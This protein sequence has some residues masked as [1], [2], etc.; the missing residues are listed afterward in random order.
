MADVILLVAACKTQLKVRQK[1]MG[2]LDLFIDFGMFCQSDSGG[3]PNPAFC[4]DVCS[5]FQVIF[6]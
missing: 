5:Y 1:K 6:C 4:G 3:R 2:R